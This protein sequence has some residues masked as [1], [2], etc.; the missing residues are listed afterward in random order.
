[1]AHRPRLAL[2][3][4]GLLLMLA[5]LSLT[6]LLQ[7]SQA[8]A[9]SASGPLRLRV[10]SARSEPRALGGAGVTTGAPVTR[11]RW[12]INQDNTGDP[13]QARAAGCSPSDPSYPE[14][15]R[16]PSIRAQNGFAPIIAQGDE[17]QLSENISRT[18]PAGRYLISV[19]AD[20]YKID[21]QWF[22][23][24][25]SGSGIVTVAA[26]PLPLPTAT[27]RAKVFEDSVSTNGQPDIPAEAGLA[28]F[29]AT[30]A[31]SLGEVTTDVYGNPLCTQ[32]SSYDPPTP[33]PGTGGQ[34]ISDANGDVVIPNLGPNR[35]AV[36][37]TPPNG[38]QWI[39]TTTLEGN[40]DWDTWIQEGSTGFDTEFAIAG[41]PFP[42]TIFGFVRPNTNFG[43]G[44]NTIRGVV[45]GAKVYVPFTGGLPYNGG[46]WGGLNGVKVDK[47][48][49][50]PWVALTD[51]NNADRTVWVGQGGADGSF[52]I[53]NVPDGDYMVTYWDEPQTYILDMVSATVRGGGVTDL[54]VLNLAGWFT[55]VSGKVCDDTN[56]NGKCESGE[57][58]IPGVAIA[59]KRRT[60]SV[61]DRGT[62]AVVTDA[63]GNY[64]MDAVYP[65]TQWLVIEAYSDR[66]Y[67]TG[68]TYQADNQP[69]E[70]TLLGQGVDVNI[71]PIIG[72]SGRLDWGVRPY[73]ATGRSER[74]RN[75]GIVGSVSYDTTR[76]ETDPRYAAVENWQVGIPGLNVNLYAPVPCTLGSYTSTDGS[77][78]VQSPNGGGSSYV[79]EANGAIR[80]AGPPLQT[81][82]TEAWQRPTGCTT[83]G[84]DSIPFTSGALPTDPAAEC[85][86]AP[87]MGVQFGNDF[88][89]VDGNFGFGD[90]AA[91]DYL[92]EVEI[93]NDMF[94]QP[95]YQ[96]TRE[97]DI[98]I[99]DGDS[100]VPQ[101]QAPP[102][103][104]AGALHT[105][106]VAT[107]GADGYPAVTLP[108]GIVVPASTPTINPNF[109]AGGGSPA[110]GQQ[111][112]LCN[113][114]FVTLSN[115][116]S[117]A[118]AFTLFTPVP[119][120]GRYFG[121]IVD[122]L[123]LSTNPQDLLFGEKAG[124]ANSPIGI[125]DF[126]NR[127]VTTVQSDPNGIF[128]VLLPST[129]TINCPSPSGVCA[130]LYRLVGNDPGVPGRLNPTYNPVF[131]TIAAT[132]EVFP[133][134]II[135][136]DLAPTQVG[137]S[138]QAPGSQN[139]AP[140]MCALDS[141]QPQLFAVS[142]PYV[143][144]S[145]TA[146]TFPTSR[147]ITIRG[148]GFGAAQGSGS[149]TLTAANGSVY[150]PQITSWSDTQIIA[151]FNTRPAPGVYQL[152][153]TASSGLNSVNGLSFHVLGGSGGNAY[154][155]TVYAVTPI[156]ADPTLPPPPADPAVPA[157][158]TFGR[159]QSAI[160]AAASGSGLVVVYPGGVPDAS[161]PAYNPQRAYFENLIID[162]RVKLQGV[163]PGGVYANGT[164]VE[165]SLIDG[166]AFGGDTPLADAWRAR[167][168]GLAWQGNQDVA[169]GAVITL[170]AP[171]QTT[172]GSATAAPD[173]RAAIDGFG[174]QGGNQ[175]GFPNN[176]NQIGGTPI[177]GQAPNVQTQGGAIFAN[178]YVRWLQ[179]SNNLIQGNGGAYG[180]IRIGTPDLP[181]PNTDGQNDGLALLNNRI[182]ANGG[183]NL[184]GAVGLFAGAN[185]YE[186]ARNDLC[187]NFSAEY[188]GAISHYGRSDGGQIHDN[189]IYF[190]R[191]Y[192]EGGAIMIAGQLPATPGTLS[193]GAGPVNIFNNLVQG[194]LSNDDGGGIR[195]L[196]AG[197]FPYNIYNNAIV[198]N[199]STHE[200]GGIALDDAPNVRVF[201]NT[202]MKNITT[203]TALTSNG[204][205]APAGLSTAQNSAQ[206]QA[207][208]PSGSPTF[209]RPLLFNNIFWDNRA[210]SFIGNV[211]GIGLPGDPNPIN[212]WDIGA[213]DASGTLDITY[214]VLQSA[215]GYNASATNRVGL[216]P[217]VISLYDTSVAVLPWR[218]NPGM[219][220][221]QLVAVD[222][223]PNLLGNYHLQGTS[224]AVNLGTA[225][226]CVTGT[227]CNPAS[228][229]NRVSAPA[230]DIDRNVRPAFGGYDSGS[231]EIRAAT[232]NLAIS[233]TN[234]VASVPSGGAVSYAI[235]VSNGG[236]DP[237][238][239]AT[240]ADTLPAQLTNASWTC[241][242]S[243]G[244]TC[245]AASGSGGI[246]TSVA[247][248]NGGTATFTLN[249]TVASG[250]IGGSI[251]NTASVTAPSGT[252]DPALG[253]NTASDTDF[254]AAPLPALT[255]LDAFTRANANTLGGS[256]SQTVLL[257]NASIRVNSNQASA[258]L[259]GTA[260]WNGAGNVFGARQG[261]AFTFA[262]APVN[263]P[264]LLTSGLI[265]KASGGSAAAPNSYIL[266]G[267]QG[268]QVTVATTTNG[269]TF[270]TRATYAATFA[271]GE[272][273]SATA[274]ADG[275]VNVYRTSGAVTTQLGSVT[276]PTSGANAWA[277]GAS[278]GRIGIM[279]PTNARADNFAGG[280]LP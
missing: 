52:Q 203:A 63:N 111:R 187:G 34:C 1:M 124:V 2:H 197:N 3:R 155:P 214:S 178:A 260:I 145:N 215:A 175:Q 127:L 10:V 251:T 243:P 271:S 118:P 125:Y 253:N 147:Q 105:V 98:N 201:H 229:P 35:Y 58:G 257:G 171:Q 265:L 168:A 227:T 14:N 20:G 138:I 272:T 177:P 246:N 102:P 233:K 136:A 76:N 141:T 21:G 130:S 18:L 172:F 81:Y 167:L 266:V 29:R 225:F 44:A 230:F 245:G 139:N 121:Y 194:N 114:K 206:L 267:Y 88:A 142:Q 269:L 129:N 195:F 156:P 176:I 239:G 244:S 274:Y 26:Q 159:I 242:A 192:D 221:T 212:Y 191:S 8:V 180:A 164:T 182:V 202:V 231:D 73:D 62:T 107:S 184:A 234:G 263:N 148:I 101:P 133:G 204:M 224:P 213:A 82:V 36:A 276:I 232:A 47:P 241:V 106:D 258:A 174:I 109:A 89:A 65:L 240:V 43:G 75:G 173:F 200:G 166:A 22:S 279:L 220:T 256:W 144:V 113:V 217:Q 49:S 236:P 210:G 38:Q 79:A 28:G 161:N 66:L 54:G 41:E 275:T 39:Q 226:A 64:E 104:C 216:D 262:N 205:P 59:V 186:I 72:L 97:E 33:I 158:R 85:L 255:V 152:Q 248:L 162:R 154:N 188:G 211:S 12:M 90:L 87:L 23:I 189:R 169:E 48:I 37:M 110:E 264:A 92:V 261:A 117:I 237:V 16:W 77:A 219:I 25:L 146:V 17:T 207:T 153:I 208:L 115:G 163:G 238:T 190:N 53:P 94:G 157:S 78:C 280:T 223:P 122:D 254:V 108:S 116:R 56:N 27:I 11:Y 46:I 196:M 83:R 273:L 4:I 103:A 31:D 69:Q 71:L 84:V 135:P 32:Y 80:R 55:T 179:V 74:L 68:V 183:T 42:F 160:N 19:L 99:F 131:R 50:N 60:N 198:N 165:G 250:L 120:P 57:A 134:D 30:V 70:T 96:V 15:C 193:P 6:A 247:L 270:T 137:V 228:N 91:G 128:E 181:A 24:P 51:L 86:E 268:G 149:L 9:Q 185:G 126:A 61:M 150:T 13:T 222:L 132:F 170:V 277:P 95:I 278:G 143:R 199:V 249:A 45:T 100:Y 123:N 7:P 151:T 140:A 218:G 119:L 112:P 235:V 209:S 40:H 252:S 259:G 93:P 67:T 5:A